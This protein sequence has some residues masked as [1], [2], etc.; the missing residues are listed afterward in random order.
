MH[1]VCAN[2]QIVGILVAIG[3]TYPAVEFDGRQL[4]SEMEPHRFGAIE[5]PGGERA[6]Q[7]GTV[8]RDGGK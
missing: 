5:R 6:L 4:L 2:H 3:E 1:S 7:I 8:N